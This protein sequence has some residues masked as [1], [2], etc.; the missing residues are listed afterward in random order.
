MP[1]KIDIK[2]III[3]EKFEKV[4]K[5][6]EDIEKSKKEME[7]IQEDIENK[8]PFDYNLNSTNKGNEKSIT[9]QLKYAATNMFIDES[10]LDFEEY[11]IMENES[12]ENFGNKILE[13]E[14][15]TDMLEEYEQP[16]YLSKDKLM[17]QGPDVSLMD[18]FITKPKKEKKKRRNRL[19]DE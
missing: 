12:I 7:K 13:S 17:F 5:K 18:I 3:G 2:P 8:T 9:E 4:Q 1:E 19:Y 16:K 10:F 15:Y 14:E 11:D 6:A